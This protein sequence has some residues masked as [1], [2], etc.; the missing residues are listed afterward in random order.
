MIATAIALYFN[1]DR[2]FQSYILTR[3]PA[4]GTGLTKLEDN[5]LVHSQLGNLSSVPTV[6]STLAPELTLGGQ[7][8]LT[9]LH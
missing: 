2:S 5:P 3:F 1:V 4:Y 8:F 6:S 7:W 9:H